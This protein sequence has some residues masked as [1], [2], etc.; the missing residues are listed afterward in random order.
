MVLVMVLAAGLGLWL[1][2]SQKVTPA[3]ASAGGVHIV[4]QVD[5]IDGESKD[6]DHKGWIDLLAFSQAMQTVDLPGRNPTAVLEDILV[7]KEIDKSSTRIADK[8]VNM[9]T[10][11][12]VKIHLS[13][14][15]GGTREVFYAY[16]LKNV[17]VTSYSIGG[18]G[19]PI[20]QIT[21]SFEE[22]KATYTE[23][24]AQGKTKGNAEYSWKK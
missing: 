14:S 22:L 15:F 17:K 10:I 9:A 18:Y 2:T 8:V 23:R 7:T 6:I 12:T 3:S 21:L 11:P 13:Q 1:Y 24:D 16:E 4:M 20:E 5:G 19:L